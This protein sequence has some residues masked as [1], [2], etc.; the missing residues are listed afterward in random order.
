MAV[1][2]LDILQLSAAE[3]AYA[4]NVEQYIDGILTEYYNNELSDNIAVEIS[5]TTMR[6]V[7]RNSTRRGGYPKNAV[8]KYLTAVYHKAGWIVTYIP[9][10]SGYDA[11]LRFS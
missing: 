10:E 9:G 3:L 7:V 6:N 2:K 4:K 8:I 5:L 11:V 1:N